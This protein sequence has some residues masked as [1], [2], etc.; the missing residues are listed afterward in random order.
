MIVF[1]S[2][3]TVVNNDK[4]Y[5]IQ[6]P[7]CNIKI[8]YTPDFYGSL[9]H[10]HNL[11]EPPPTTARLKFQGTELIAF[12]FVLA[13][14]QY[15]MAYDVIRINGMK[16]VHTPISIPN[17][18]RIKVTVTPEELNDYKRKLHP[19]AY[20]AALLMSECEIV[21]LMELTTPIHKI[22]EDN[23]LLGCLY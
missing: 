17:K 13:E 11:G 1:E 9:V 5:F 10:I 21:N 7:Q 18:T 14:I 4:I 16:K 6:T 8:I 3:N 12:S 19:A 22:I 23:Y 15:L 2:I 20:N